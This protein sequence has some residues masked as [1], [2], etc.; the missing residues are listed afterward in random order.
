MAII[1]TASRPSL[2]EIMVGE[3]ITSVHVNSLTIVNNILVRQH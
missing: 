3:I 2:K 1:R